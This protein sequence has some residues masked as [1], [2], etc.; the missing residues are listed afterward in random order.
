MY[1]ALT[2]A[3]NGPTAM[4]WPTGRHDKL[5]NHRAVIRVTGIEM[6]PAIS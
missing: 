2:M 4:P 5:M 3:P 6:H 1:L